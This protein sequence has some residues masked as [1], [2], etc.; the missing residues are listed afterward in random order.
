MKH[1]YLKVLTAYFLLAFILPLSGMVVSG[2]E[3]PGI[4]DT[5]LGGEPDGTKAIL[6]DLATYESPMLITGISV[7]NWGEV[8][9][10][11]GGIYNGTGVVNYGPDGGYITSHLTGVELTKSNVSAPICCLI[12]VSLDGTV[13]SVVTS[14]DLDFSTSATTDY[15]TISLELNRIFF[16]GDGLTSTDIQQGIIVPESITKLFIGVMNSYGWCNN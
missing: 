6:N 1:A 13:S 11:N 12:G 7:I 4:T 10:L 9:N 14:A 16:I 5:W 15:L 8:L 2:V 3:A